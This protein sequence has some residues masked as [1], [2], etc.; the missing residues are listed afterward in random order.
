MNNQVGLIDEPIKIFDKTYHIKCKPEEVDVLHKTADFLD[1]EMRKMSRVNHVKNTDQV[2]ILTALNLAYELLHVKEPLRER[3][4][5]LQKL[6]KTTL[7]THE[8]IA[9]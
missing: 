3:I 6:I 5:S 1:E 9:L 8:E 7:E 2:A 4:T